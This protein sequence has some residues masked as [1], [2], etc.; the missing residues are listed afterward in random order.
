MGEILD[1]W[2]VEAPYA[3][4]SEK[5]LNLGL[6]FQVKGKDQRDS[7]W[8]TDWMVQHLSVL[9]ARMTEINAIVSVAERF[10]NLTNFMPAVTTEWNVEEFNCMERTVS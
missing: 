8:K 3:H 4:E 10:C 1:G 2:I 5:G 7:S 6:A 9:S